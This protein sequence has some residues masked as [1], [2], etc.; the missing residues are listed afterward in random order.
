MFPFLSVLR[1][2]SVFVDALFRV[3]EAERPCM[4]PSLR[5]LGWQGAAAYGAVAGVGWCLLLGRTSCLS[6]RPALLAWAR[7]FSKSTVLACIVLPTCR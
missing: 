6:A 2:S 3:G 5:G 1:L 7:A 4:V